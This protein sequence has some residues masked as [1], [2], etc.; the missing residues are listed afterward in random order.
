MIFITYDKKN[1][2]YYAI[3]VKLGLYQIK[4]LAITSYPSA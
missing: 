2:Q 3:R 1:K 4:H